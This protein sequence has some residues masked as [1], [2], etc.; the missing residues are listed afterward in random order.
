[1]PNPNGRSVDQWYRREFGD[2]LSVAG[3]RGETR[4]KA[5]DRD[6]VTGT[7]VP[8]GVNPSDLDGDWT[9]VDRDELPEWAVDHIED[10]YRASDANLQAVREAGGS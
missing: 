7:T 2:G 9:E 5:V 10:R 6:F 8:I 1:M 4:V 3:R